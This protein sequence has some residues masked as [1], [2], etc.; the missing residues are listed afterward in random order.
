MGITMSILIAALVLVL[1]AFA[2]VYRRVGELSGELQSIKKEIESNHLLYHARHVEHDHR[3][4]HLIRSVY[5]KGG[6]YE[7]DIIRFYTPAGHC[8]NTHE[9]KK[10]AKDMGAIGRVE[11]DKFIISW[12]K[13]DKKA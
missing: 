5:K 8:D 6:A 3:L 2:Y 1:L 10:M 7:F 4:G 12:D 11:G 9:L 13:I